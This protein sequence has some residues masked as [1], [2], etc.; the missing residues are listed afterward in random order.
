MGL[1]SNNSPRAA[2]GLPVG[3]RV[4]KENQHLTNYKA[5]HTDKYLTLKEA[6][7]IWYNR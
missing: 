4:D 5:F 7:V 1:G 6:G 2:L 3:S